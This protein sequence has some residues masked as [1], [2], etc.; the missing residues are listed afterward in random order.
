MIE[1]HQP[2]QKV[3]NMT[4]DALPSSLAPGPVPPTGRVG[5]GEAVGKPVSAGIL[6]TVSKV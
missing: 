2:R 3:R 6:K 1:S 4:P 5:V